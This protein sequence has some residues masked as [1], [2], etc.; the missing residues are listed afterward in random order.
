MKCVPSVEL[1]EYTVSV[2]DTVKG[3]LVVEVLEDTTAH[4]VVI[5]LLWRTHGRGKVDE[6]I[7]D[8]L[9]LPAAAW[10]AGQPVR[11]P[12]SFTLPPSGPTTVRG[13]LVNVDWYVRARVDLAWARDPTAEVD[14]VVERQGGALPFRYGGT[15]LAAIEEAVADKNITP[16]KIAATLL[17]LPF[18]GTSLMWLAPLNDAI[19]GGKLG[20]VLVALP[21]SLV[22]VAGFIVLPSIVNYAVWHPILAHRALAGASLTLDRTDVVAGD[23]VGVRFEVPRRS[24]RIEKV[25]VHLVCLELARETSGSTEITSTHE[26][27]KAPIRVSQEGSC[28][29][30]RAGIPADAAATFSSPNNALAW[31]VTTTVKVRGRPNP[32]YTA[33]LEVTSA[34][35]A[36]GAPSG[37]VSTSRW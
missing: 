36:L 17:T 27:W 13:T 30:G 29:V 11:L 24:A 20:H 10:S 37:A 15:S 19:D 4:G 16:T 32:T 26:R 5:E 23:V 33:Y 7:T 21:F 12:F 25:D 8:S 3:A 22:G 6:V 34:P 31:M 1:F 14:C 18:Y 28:W 9:T 2:G 35:K